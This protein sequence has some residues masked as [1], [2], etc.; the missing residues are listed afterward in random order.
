MILLYCNILGFIAV[1]ARSLQDLLRIPSLIPPDF[2]MFTFYHLQEEAAEAVHGITN[3]SI[4]FVLMCR[5]SHMNSF[6]F[7]WVEGC[8]PLTKSGFKLPKPITKESFR[9]SLALTISGAISSSFWEALL[10]HYHSDNDGLPVIYD[11]A[12]THPTLFLACVRVNVIYKVSSSVLSF[13]KILST[14]LI[15]QK[16]N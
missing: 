15:F 2:S 11:F 7:A 14:L 8:L 5:T 13:G 3:N 12:P 4:Y 6:D 16:K 10:Y 1:E 9:G